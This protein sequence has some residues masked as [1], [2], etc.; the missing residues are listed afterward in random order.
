MKGVKTR[1]ELLSHNKTAYDMKEVNGQEITITRYKEVIPVNRPWRPIRL[2]DVENCPYNRLTDGGKVISS[3]HRQRFTPQN[4][5]FLLL[6][7]I[8]VRGWVIPRA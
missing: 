6:L 4:I 7:I 2:W 8:S 5:I 1:H 3:T